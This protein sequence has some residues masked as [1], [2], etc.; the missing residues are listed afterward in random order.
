MTTAY[1]SLLGLA[2]P[3]QGELSGQWG[4]T[5]NNY[6]TQYLD[7]AVAG[8][9]TVASDTTLV[10]TTGASLDATSSQYAI[11]IASGHTA[12]I[13]ITAP[14]ASKSYLVINTSGTYTVKV[15][16]AGPTTGVT[17]AAN[18]KAVVTW[19]GSDFV[20]VSSSGGSATF[21]DVTVSGTT[22]LSNLTASTALA[23]DASKNVVSVTNTGSGNNVL[24]TSPTLTTPNLG[25]PSA[26][27]LTNATGLPI[28]TGVSG[29]GT[30]VASAL[31]V[32]TGAAGA[33]VVNGG[34]LGTP[35][36]GTVTNLT[37]TAS[38][39]INGT[40]GATTPTTG[41]FTTLSASST[42]SGTGFST[43]LASPPAIGTTTAAAGAFTTLSASSTVSGTGFSDYLASPPAIGGTAAAAG[44]FTTLSASS[45]VSGTGFSTYLASP[46]AIGGTAAAAGSF[47]TLSAS[48]TVSGTGFS[49]YLASPPAIGGTAPAAGSFTTLSASSTVSGTGFSTY[50]ASPPAIGGTAPAAGSFTT[51]SA[52]GNMTFGDADTDTITQAASYV[53]NTQLKSAKVATNTFSLAAYD[54]DGTSYTNLVTLTASNTPTLALTSTGVGT[55]NNMSIGA[56][57]ASTGDFT[58][59]SA[60]S[61]VSGTGFST[62]LASPPAIGGTTPGAGSFTT[63]TTNGNMTFGDADT[64]AIT[65]NASY[66]TGTRLKAA[67]A[68]TNTLYLSAY[69]VDGTVYTD[70]VTLTSGNTPTL[71]LT[72]TGVGTINNMSVGIT[73]PST[74]KFTAITN[75]TLTTGRVVYSTTGGLQTDSANLAFDGTTL[76]A[77]GFSTSGTTSVAAI[78][79]S[80]T[81]TG[82][83]NWVIGDADTDTITQAASYVTG[84]QLKSAKAATN[85]LSLAAYDVDGTAYTNLI[86]LTASNTPTLALTSTGVG[87][88]N[89]MSIGA[90]TA[91]TGAFTTLSA[92]ST[93]SG[94]GFSTYLAS[95]PAIGGTA[96][97]AGS[98][99]TLTASTNLSSTRIDPRVSSA[100]SASSLTPTIASYDMYAYTALAANLTINAPTGTPVDGNKLIFRILD[101]GTSRTLTWNATYTAIGVTLPTATTVSKT[102]YVGCIY[103]AAATRWDVISV[104]VQA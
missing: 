75:N 20:K 83:G 35:S 62:Y 11:L 43:Y 37:G 56:T 70:L 77:G 29:L 27:T 55:I 69:D 100:A 60:S 88:I 44:S 67:K 45:T 66:V 76:T 38:I 78:T 2:L 96:P 85:T 22:T 101:N 81:V 57:T 80:G 97:A 7:T 47:T 90:T 12:N 3:V 24:A 32:N 99:T 16:G 4:N 30:G 74:A 36:S 58:T 26:A 63:L 33:F 28:S 95:P 68:D 15:R 61:T 64:D 10:K 94:T 91:S 52:T 92:S 21:T 8:A 46:P 40:V 54:V 98:F 9:L 31:A 41:A 18:E 82:N 103:N 71:A 104:T 73:T 39:N 34:A 102:L 23:L 42:V 25:T 19:N 65:Q 72:S 79:A 48:S 51:L 13:T 5:V 14:A 49:N 17:L 87:T 93:V 6:I 1:T 84:T 50:L 86:T 59:L 53:N 89:N